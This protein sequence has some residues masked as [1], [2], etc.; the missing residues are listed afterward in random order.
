VPGLGAWLGEWSNWLGLALFFALAVWVYLD[1]RR[2]KVEA[3][4]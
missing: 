3:A 4:G 2:E 1:S